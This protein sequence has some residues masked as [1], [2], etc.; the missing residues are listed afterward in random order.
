MEFIYECEN[1]LPPDICKQLINKFETSE[2]QQITGQVG[3]GKVNIN[4]KK[5]VDLALSGTECDMIRKFLRNAY[6][7][8]H[9]KMCLEDT[10]SEVNISNPVIQKT[11][12]GGF[13][14]WHTDNDTGNNNRICAI[15]IYLNDVEESQ[16]GTT[17]FKFPDRIESIQPKTGKLLMFPSHCTYLHR[18]SILKKGNKYIITS[19]VLYHKN[20]ILTQ[21][22]EEILDE[23]KLKFVMR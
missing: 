12:V 1:F 21:I 16:G 20:D 22:H 7:Y 15:I 17:D 3:E 10:T 18:G 8:Y 23:Y 2:E 5:S 6:K 14:N 19:F 4:M 11:E 9:T 13:Y